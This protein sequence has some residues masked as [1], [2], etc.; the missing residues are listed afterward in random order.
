MKR[1]HLLLG[2]AFIAC[3]LAGSQ[4]L[5]RTA[6][7]QD[8]LPDFSGGFAGTIKGKAADFELGTKPASIKNTCSFSASLCGGS[9]TGE[10]AP[11]G[12]SITTLSGAHGGGHFWAFGGDA[13]EPFLMTGHVNKTAN[14]FKAKVL[15]G[16]GEGTSDL[17]VSAVQ[18][19]E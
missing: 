4:L 3:G 5:L 7:A 9:L 15:A 17:A 18:T 13:D 2:G 8:G 12:G 1:L 6:T 11:T 19:I 10:I 16:H 14:K